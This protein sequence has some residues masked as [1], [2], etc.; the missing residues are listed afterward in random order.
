MQRVTYRDRRG[1]FHRPPRP[2]EKIPGIIKDT[3]A[4]QIDERGKTL[5]TIEQVT[6]KKIIKTVMPGVL[7]VG[8]FDQGHVMAALRKTNVMGRLQRM[9]E[10]PARITIFVEGTTPEGKRI[11]L[12]YDVQAPLAPTQRKKLDLYTVGAILHVIRQA[13]YRM[14]YP[15]AIVE[16]MRHRKS[17][18]VTSPS[19]RKID[20]QSLTAIRARKIL[21]QVT[22]Q[23]IIEA[24]RGERFVYGRN[25]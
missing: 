16:A 6:D 18:W 3:R 23:V 22:L 25:V 7:D 21:T 9:R 8:G 15:M 12:K 4:V 10:A 19:G 20:L 1:R 13:G 24:G 11:Q 2:G 5:R 14:N 17:I